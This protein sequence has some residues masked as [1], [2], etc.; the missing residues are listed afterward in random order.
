MIVATSVDPTITI[1]TFDREARRALAGVFETTPQGLFVYLG[2]KTDNYDD[3]TERMME[4]HLRSL[5]YARRDARPLCWVPVQVTW[6]RKRPWPED[7]P[8]IK[9]DLDAIIDQVAS[10]C[11]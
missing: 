1:H 2:G 9:G 8:W 7:D 3:E 5:G 10:W 11:D 6:I 4:W